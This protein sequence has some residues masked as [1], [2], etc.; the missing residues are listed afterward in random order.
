MIKV[1]KHQ[2]IVSF[3]A[4]IVLAIVAAILIVHFATQYHYVG[5]L[6]KVLESHDYTEYDEMTYKNRVL[7]G[8][9]KCFCI[10]SDQES[11]TYF[12]QKQKIEKSIWYNYGKCSYFASQGEA[13][14]YFSNKWS[15][16]FDVSPGTTIENVSLRQGQKNIEIYYAIDQL[17]T[18]R[19]AYIDLLDGKCVLELSAN[20]TDEESISVLLDMLEKTGCSEELQVFVNELT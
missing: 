11:Q 1:S 2:W 3:F 17:E 19:Y 8:Q 14:E 18:H 9:K 5:E 15:P 16:R 12:G 6:N 7:N 13:S 20:L 4:L 10:L